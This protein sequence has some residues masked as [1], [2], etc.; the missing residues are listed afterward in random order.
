MTREERREYRNAI[1]VI[2]YQLLS[3][4]FIANELTRTQLEAIIL[5]VRSMEERMKETEMP[6][7]KQIAML[8]YHIKN[9]TALLFRD[10]N[11]M[12]ALQEGIMAMKWM[13]KDDTCEMLWRGVL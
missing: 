2:D 10:K 13:M 4:P 6:L 8:S 1:N 3:K 12:D 9:P 11:T 5:A 7:R